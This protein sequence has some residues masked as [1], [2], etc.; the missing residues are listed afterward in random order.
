M[1]CVLMILGFK[2]WSCGPWPLFRKSDFLQR[3]ECESVA[4]DTWYNLG[5]RGWGLGPL[6]FVCCVSVLFFKKI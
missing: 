2:P 4:Q 3:R 6:Y 1:E 5:T